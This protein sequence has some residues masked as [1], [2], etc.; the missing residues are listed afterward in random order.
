M[1]SVLPEA[2]QIGVGVGYFNEMFLSGGSE[3]RR[4]HD[5]ELGKR[6]GKEDGDK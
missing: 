4:L 1:E 2:E 3:M 5:F 6:E